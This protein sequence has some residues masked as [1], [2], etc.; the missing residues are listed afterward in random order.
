MRIRPTALIAALPLLIAPLL[1]APVFV[2]S[3]QAEPTRDPAKVEGG[4]FKVDPDHTQIEFTVDHFGFSLYSGRFAQPTGLL[5]LAPKA[6]ATSSFDISVP[7]QSVNT[8]SDKLTGELKSPDWLDA[9]HFPTITF[10]S[11]SVK[12][13][14]ATQADVTGDLTLH[15]V[16]KPV[17]LHVTLHGAGENPVFKIYTIGFQATGHIKRSDFGVTKFVPYVSDDV[18]LTLNAAFVKS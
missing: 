4:A 10:H 12:P 6:P 9:E 18:A 8:A 13:T 16:T 5:N 7:V 15:G 1:V 3:V 17:T 2:A 14:G 11:V